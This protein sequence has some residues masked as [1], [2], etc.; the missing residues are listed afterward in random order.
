MIAACRKTSKREAD[1]RL[2]YG[3]EKMS[4]LFDEFIRIG[5]HLNK[6]GIIPT[7]MGSLGLEYVT[8]VNWEPSDIDIHVPGDPRGWEAPDERRIYDWDKILPMM[9]NLGYRLIDVHEHEFQKDEIHAEFGSI[10]SL[11]DFAGISESDIKPVQL[12]GV[13]FR[14]PSME[15]KIDDREKNY[16]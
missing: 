4:I 8:K 5:S 7:L 15:K 10:A 1:E 14:V 6:I 3:E 2:A 9:K 12:D 16:R 11:S 13:R